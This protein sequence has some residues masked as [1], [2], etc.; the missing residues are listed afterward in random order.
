MIIFTDIDKEKCCSRANSFTNIH[1]SYWVNSGI[2]QFCEGKGVLFP[3][4]IVKIYNI[5]TKTA[6]ILRILTNL[7]FFKQPALYSFLR[8]NRSFAAIAVATNGFCLHCEWKNFRICFH[9]QLKFL[10]NTNSSLNNVNGTPDWTHFHHHLTW[11]F[12]YWFCAFFW[13][14]CVPFFFKE[15]QP[16]CVCR[17]NLNTKPFFSWK[18]LLCRYFGDVFPHHVKSCFF[19]LP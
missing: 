12:T 10:C 15:T 5:M 8:C 18:A 13:S 4:C 17:S 9:S 6:V 14:N 16:I 2:L 3:H 7:F 1:L 19:N 11:K